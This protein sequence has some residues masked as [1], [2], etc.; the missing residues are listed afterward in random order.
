MTPQDIVLTVRAADFAARR[1]ADQRRK[2][3]AREPYVNHV[4]EVAALLADATEGRDSV[5]VAAGYLHDTL[6]DTETTYEDLVDL[7]G[8]EVAEVVAEV[9]DDKSL[10]KAERKRRQVETAAH[11]SVRARLLKIADKTSNLRALTASPPADWDLQRVAE[12]AE[13][14]AQVVAHCRGLNRPLEQAFDAALTEARA[15]I[16]ARAA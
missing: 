14:A 2:G 9:T 5:L 12:Y 1:H 7:F 13:W 4:A 3:A 11:K 16:A 8:P 6:E 10:P 15:F